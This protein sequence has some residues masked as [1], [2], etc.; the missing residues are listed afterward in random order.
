MTSTQPLAKKMK[1]VDNR[2][3]F[4]NIAQ[5]L[6]TKLDISDRI[7]LPLVEGSFFV[8]SFRNLQGVCSVTREAYNSGLSG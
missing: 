7:S 6:L 1:P 4:E 2:R 8:P 3:L 5:K